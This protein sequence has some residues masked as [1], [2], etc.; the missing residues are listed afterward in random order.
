M[1]KTALAAAAVLLSVGLLSPTQAL[2][3]DQVNTKKLRD[4][5]TVNGILQHER[6]FQRIANNN[7][8]T[9]ASGTP[10]FDASADYVVKKLRRPATKSRGES[11]TFPFFRDVEPPELSEVS[12]TER[13]FET[14]T[15]TYSGSGDIT[16][17]LVLIGG[18]VLPPT[19]EPSS[20]SGCAAGDFPPN[21][22]P[23]SIALIQRG[24]CTFEE[25]VDNAQAAG[26]A[27][28][29]I[30]NE[31]QSPDRTDL[32][33]GTLGNPKTIPAVGISFADGQTLYDEAQTGDVEV[34]VATSTETNLNAR[35][36]QRHRRFPT[37]QDQGPDHSG[38]RPSRLRDR[39]TRNQ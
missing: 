33:T 2:A 15:F 34:H 30:F 20:A 25:K 9:R 8:G 18:I 39:R 5:V 38:R 24:T 23:N 21:P 13:D 12:P 31:G 37:R 29:I 6:A 3:I 35:D 4:A 7:D 16:G 1:R 11:F 10:G 26:Y 36:R 28:V 32:L 27:A 17:P 19:P 22:E 14:A